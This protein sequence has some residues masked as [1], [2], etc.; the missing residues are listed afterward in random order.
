ML[1]HDHTDIL[2]CKVMEDVLNPTMKELMAHTTMDAEYQMIVNMLHKGTS[3]DEIMAI[4]DLHRDHPAHKF[5]SQ[6]DAMAVDDTYGFMTYHNRIIV[7]KDAR[8]VVLSLLH[9]QHMGQM[10]TLMNAQQ[11]YFLLGMTNDLKLIVSMYHSKL[12]LDLSQDQISK[13]SAQQNY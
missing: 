10:K 8:K 4:R 6:W 5:K 9:T 2:I 13:N 7:P 12:R 3:K 11:L 1:Y